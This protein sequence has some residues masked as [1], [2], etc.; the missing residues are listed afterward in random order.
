MALKKLSTENM[1]TL[2]ADLI[3][4]GSPERAE[5]E[6]VPE[7]AALM[8]QIEAAHRG[9]LG[10]QPITNA[11]I[12]KLT[13]RLNELDTRHDALVRGIHARLESEILIEVAPAEAAKLERAKTALFP[14]GT[15]IVTRS[16][17][18]QAGEAK[19]R[20]AR[21]SRDEERVLGK[22]KCHDG[23]TLLEHYQALQAIAGEIDATEKKRAALTGEGPTPAETVRARN[24]WIRVINALA[25][26]LAATGVDEAPILGRVR[27]FE[28]KA[29]G[30][31]PVTPDE[32]SEP[33]DPGLEPIAP[34]EPVE[35]VVG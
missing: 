16:W 28:A 27:A 29:E 15:S 20:A 19:L 12:A 7:A 8:P 4:R 18:E 32:P 34:V 17:S 3:R 21:V 14:T 30:R 35:P 9:L 11:E 26:V 23:A 24:Q 2:S 5:I 6:A 33:T 13:S 31:T 25:M 10:S 1:V 22:L